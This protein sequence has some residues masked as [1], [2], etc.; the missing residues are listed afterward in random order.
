MPIEKILSALTICK[1]KLCIQFL[2]RKFLKLRKKHTTYRFN[3]N[4]N[5]EFTIL[6]VLTYI[7]DNNVTTGI[8]G[9]CTV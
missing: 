7:L 1:I 2:G 8:K 6:P 9:A 5:L 4:F 3:P